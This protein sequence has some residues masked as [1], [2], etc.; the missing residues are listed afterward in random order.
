MVQHRASAGTKSVHCIGILTNK[1]VSA[2]AWEEA[3][4]MKVQGTEAIPSG[5]YWA[6]CLLSQ[7]ILFMAV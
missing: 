2:M 3:M 7:T 1:D 4:E 5:Q 6:L